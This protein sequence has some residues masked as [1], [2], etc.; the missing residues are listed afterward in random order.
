MLYI[1]RARLQD[2][3]TCYITIHKTIM[4][5][6]HQLIAIINTA[7]YLLEGCENTTSSSINAGVPRQ[8]SAVPIKWLT[9]SEKVM[10]YI[11]GIGSPTIY[12]SNYIFKESNDPCINHR[13]ICIVYGTDRISNNLLFEPHLQTK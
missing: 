10:L 1:G 13:R 6:H 2:R 3:V 8:L 7:S 11:Y 9:F 5:D 4:I 12:W